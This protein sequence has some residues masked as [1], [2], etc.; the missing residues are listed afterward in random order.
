MKEGYSSSYLVKI[1]KYKI[2]NNLGLSLC[3]LIE[4]LPIIYHSFL[5]IYSMISNEQPSYLKDLSYIS[6]I[7]V[8][9]DYFGNQYP[10]YYLIIIIAFYGFFIGY[11]F[12]FQFFSFFEKEIISMIIINFYE[13]FWFRIISIVW[14][15]MLLYYIVSQNFII[16][17][18]GI[19]TLCIC[20]TMIYY[21]FD[22]TRTYFPI[23]SLGLQSTN[24][25]I[26]IL[27]EKSNLILKLLICFEYNFNLYF[28]SYFFSSIIMVVNL[29][30]V[31]F[32]LTDFFVEEINIIYFSAVNI[33]HISSKIYLSFIEVI[34]LL[35]QGSDKIICVIS[36]NYLLISIYFSFLLINNSQTK[37]L[38]FSN[39]F[40][41]VLSLITEDIEEKKKEKVLLL[42]NTHKDFCKTKSCVLC[43]KYNQLFNCK[44]SY[45]FSLFVEK[46]IILIYKSEIKP[47]I[48]CFHNILNKEQRRHWYLIK[49]YIK[50][51]I[52]KNNYIK[53]MM[54]YNQ[55]YSLLIKNKN[56]CLKNNFDIFSKNFTMNLY[57]LLSKIVQKYQIQKKKEL[58]SYLISVEKMINTINHFLNF[59][60]LFIK[61]IPKNIHEIKKLGESFSKLKKNL[62]LETLNK[63]ENKTYYSC[64]LCGYIIEE[65]YNDQIIKNSNFYDIITSF[66][67]LLDSNYTKEKPLFIVYNILTSSLI[68]KI[69][70]K[71]LI[72]YVNKPLVE[73]FP[74]IIRTE[75]KKR[76]LEMLYK[77]DPKAILHFYYSK[78]SKSTIEKIIMKMIESPSLNPEAKQNSLVYIF[79]QYLIEKG[80]ILI[81]ENTIIN[82]QSQKILV[83]IS[84]KITQFLPEASSFLINSCKSFNNLLY[85]DMI[86]KGFFSITN[87]KNALKN[88]G[89]QGT[90]KTKKHDN[91]YKIEL[92]EVIDKYEIYTINF[93]CSK[94]GKGVKIVQSQLNDKENIQTNND[95]NDK[96]WID[97]TKMSSSLTTDSMN[98]SNIKQR[99]IKKK[100]QK[101]KYKKFYNQTYCLFTFNIFVLI[102]VSLFCSFQI[103]NSLQVE[104]IYTSILSYNNFQ[105]LFYLTSLSVFSLICFPEFLNETTCSN[106]YSVYSINQ[107]EKLDLKNNQTINEYL[108][109]ELPFK[110]SDT[111]V[112]LRNWQ[113]DQTL[114]NIK[115]LVQLLQKNLTFSILQEEPKIVKIIEL[116]M[117]FQESMDILVNILNIL[118]SKNNFT[119]YPFYPI[120]I[121]GKDSYDLSNIYQPRELSKN[122]NYL[123]DYQRNLYI[124]ILNFQKYMAKLEDIGSV[125]QNFFKTRI[126]FSV[127]LL[128]IFLIICVLLNIAMMILS[129]TFI[130]HSKSLYLVY[131]LI[132]IN[133]L[134]DYQFID[135][136]F[137]KEKE[138]KSL[139]LLYSQNPVKIALNIQ[140]LKD[141]EH[142]RNKK[143]QEIIKPIQEQKEKEE[144]KIIKKDF[145]S[146]ILFYSGL[147]VLILFF[148]YIFCSVIISWYIIQSILNVQ[149]MNEYTYDNYI[150]TNHIII[151]ADFLS[152]M[153]STNQTDLMLSN[154]FNN[155]NKG[156]GFIRNLIDETLLLSTSVDKIDKINKQFKSLSQIIDVKCEE[157]FSGNQENYISKV[158]QKYPEKQYQELFINY[159]LSLPIISQYKNE[160]MFI[161]FISYQSE[162]ILEFI[163]S[164]SFESIKEVKNNDLLYDLYTNIICVIRPLRKRI[165][166]YINKQLVPQFLINNKIFIVFFLVFNVLYEIATLLIIKLYIINKSILLIKEIIMVGKAFECFY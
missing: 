118:S 139:L 89:F 116:K 138:L 123:N 155:E 31:C 35:F 132:I 111:A 11:I 45:N 32:L 73:L 17:F 80:I 114:F 82:H 37:L 145:D 135:Y 27:C 141:K 36:I 112:Q 77:N 2:K 104:S 95:W 79:C 44:G 122:K 20:G 85:E 120:S 97:H 93:N 94:I 108:L 49:L 154:Y 65:I 142:K 64:I 43:S 21:H 90:F 60:E 22:N 100:E 143:T 34:L 128:G 163:N 52:N 1:Q 137:K 149:K 58:F 102:L 113:S 166:N 148:L 105:S 67:E 131:Y 62:N 18:V 117:S 87:L 88:K 107:M 54:K 126:N 127:K 51:L 68:I 16:R 78:E 9:R 8:I 12:F 151:I 152:I 7:D 159:C 83:G 41:R 76:F 69:T 96:I 101:L 56:Y 48:R 33:L 28:C 109:D 74:S 91:C 4:I 71:E 57:L 61:E 38:N 106:Q 14:F 47:F 146:L 125:L 10:I 160:K 19:I 161:S 40:G 157:M 130:K 84:E 55:I 119:T 150:L 103:L 42:L 156:K 3:S 13:L 26:I 147:K 5:S 129:V 50:F 23:P 53:F 46:V 133:K 66:E 25:I 134:S 140:R 124:L 59:L 158:Y 30:T 115:E 144:L 70:G 75:G 29:I 72:S 153:I 164:T 86:T 99:E 165:N 39:Y 6:Y 92:C 162:K 110:A 63:K 81:F 98:S 121:L 15:D 24:E 136:Y